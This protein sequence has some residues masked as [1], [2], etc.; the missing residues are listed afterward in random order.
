MA[1]QA[2]ATP[3]TPSSDSV[4]LPSHP[5]H[6]TP[7]PTTAPRFPSTGPSTGSSELEPILHTPRPSRD[8]SDVVLKDTPAEIT[9]ETAQQHDT[10]DKASPPSFLDLP[11]SPP[12]RASRRALQSPPRIA[13]TPSDSRHSPPME[14][15]SPK[16]E[17]AVQQ[18]GWAA[19]YTLTGDT[20]ATTGQAQLPASLHEALEALSD[21]ATSPAMTPPRTPSAVLSSSPLSDRASPR[22]S[23][24]PSPASPDPPIQRSHAPRAP[25]DHANNASSSSSS[26]SSKSDEKSDTPPRPRVTYLSRKRSIRRDEAP[27]PTAED[28]I[29]ELLTPPGSSQPTHNQGQTDFLSDHRDK[30]RRQ[31]EGSTLAG[32]EDVF[33]KPHRSF[34]ARPSKLAKR[35]PPSPGHITAQQGRRTAGP[36]AY[37]EPEKKVRF[38]TST[39]LQGATSDAGA[40]S[41]QTDTS[42][43]RSSLVTR[44]H[45]RSTDQTKSTG[46]LRPSRPTPDSPRPR[47][48]RRPA[49]VVQSARDQGMLFMRAN[50]RAVFVAQNVRIKTGQLVTQ[51][52]PQHPVLHT[53]LLES[54]CAGCLLDTKG[55][56][57]VD[58]VDETFVMGRFVICSRC[59]RVWFCS[60][61]SWIA[62]LPTLC[63]SGSHRTI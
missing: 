44:Q 63:Q 60:L 50:P 10:E 3:P 56:A 22:S 11:H 54:H 2:S 39:R 27:S 47:L 23:P 4:P 51:S 57:E 20:V 59:E 18:F 32:Q 21:H 38:A 34:P 61:V 41:R 43:P 49:P 48:T 33:A 24:P 45:L 62:F 17:T 25:V 19:P 12:S 15:S 55:R 26:D 35:Y 53:R 52:T 29:E 30:R 13:I 46:N 6:L 42:S 5:A 28:L 31:V 36:S 16:P 7:T 9:P 14:G 37:A 8:T 40:S 58:K 1:D